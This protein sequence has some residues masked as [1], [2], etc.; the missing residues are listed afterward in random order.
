MAKNLMKQHKR[1]QRMAEAKE[2]ATD[3]VLKHWEEFCKNA[4]V[5]ILY[6]LHTVFGFGKKR[7]ERFYKALIKNQFEMIDN[8]RCDGDDSH[9]WVMEARLKWAGID[10][11]ALQ[12][13]AD[14]IEAQW[15]AE[16]RKGVE[17]G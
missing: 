9:Y 16:K 6:T 13:E 15:E 1:R 2:E 4:D 5:A 3:L 17:N 7:C 11:Q 12:K 14:E 10:V 8:F